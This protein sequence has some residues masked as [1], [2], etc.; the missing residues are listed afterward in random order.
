MQQQVN[1]EQLANVMGDGVVISDAKGDIIFGML[2]QREFLAS[3][4]LKHSEKAWT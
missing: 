1:F 3:R 4:R 2:L